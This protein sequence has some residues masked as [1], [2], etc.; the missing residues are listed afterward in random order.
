MTTKQHPQSDDIVYRGFHDDESGELR[1]VSLCKHLRA[2][3][4]HYPGEAVATGAALK[5]AKADATRLD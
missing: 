5:L 3:L 2:E 1:I 4:D